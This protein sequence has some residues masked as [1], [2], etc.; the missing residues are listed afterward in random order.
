MLYIMCGGFIRNLA[1]IALS[2]V[3]RIQEETV[4]KIEWTFV[5]FKLLEFW[6][7]WFT[8]MSEHLKIFCVSF[9]SPVSCTLC[10]FF[11]LLFIL[12]P[13][14]LECVSK[15]CLASLIYMLAR[16]S[17][18]FNSVNI[19]EPYPVHQF[20]STNW[21]SFFKLLKLY[22]LKKKLC[23]KHFAHELPNCG[24]QA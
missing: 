10:L 15:F 7:S 23:P 6:K 24:S 12:N 20:C 17:S 3:A 21:I 4:L 18:T 9:K 16:R 5:C 14:Y 11:L 22:K 19:G 1:T 2:R 8:V 13:E